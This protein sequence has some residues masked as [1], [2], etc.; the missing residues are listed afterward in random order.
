MHKKSYSSRSESSGTQSI[1]LEYGVNRRIFNL[2][3]GL[4]LFST[5]F[6]TLSSLNQAAKA[7][8]A[9]LALGDSLT[10]GYG[11][12]QA[13]SFPAQLERTLKAKGH[14]IRIINGGVSGDTTAG[15]LSRLNWLMAD[16]PKAVIVTLGGNDGLRG[17]SP[18]QSREN[19]QK[20][21]EHF[22]KKR[23]P[24]LLAGMLAPPNLGREFS[25]QFNSNYKALATKNGTLFYPFFLEG[26]AGKSV[27]NQMDGIH[28]NKNGVELIVKK[29]LP[30][31]E[32]LIRRA[33]T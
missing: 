9:I 26:V 7:E 13:D 8:T 33:E 23:I 10:A 30:M 18:K 20:I 1:A 22:H 29:I 25:D 4:F 32:K 16:N 14:D 28:P 19:L 27:Y 11:L 3:C 17:L 31:V 21:I 2:I 5:L 24:V 15:G 12:D 6:L